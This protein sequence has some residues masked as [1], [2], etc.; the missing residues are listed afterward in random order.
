M[1]EFTS[2]VVDSFEVTSPM[3][4][5]VAVSNPKN[6]RRRRCAIVVADAPAKTMPWS[7]CGRET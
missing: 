5:D 2:E 3:E 7:H 4:V 6:V 1:S